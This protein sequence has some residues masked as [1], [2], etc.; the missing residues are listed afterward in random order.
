MGDV[1]RAP[2]NG[3]FVTGFDACSQ[4]L[5]GRHWL[6]PDFAWQERQD[7]TGRWDA[8]ATQEMTKT[9]SRLN[10]PAHTCQRRS[11]GNLFDR[12]TIERLA[13]QVEGH[14]ARLLDELADKLRWGEADLVSTVSEQLPISTIGS[15]LGIPPEDH[16]HI[17]EITHNQVHAQEL[18]PT[19]SQLAVSAEATVQLRAYF[20]DLVARRR[21]APGEDVLTGWIHTWDGLEPDRETADEILY[22]LTMFVTIASLE[23]T[24]TLLSSMVA[25]LLEEPG[26]WAWLREHP[27]HIDAAIDEVLRYDPPIHINSRIAAEDTVLAGVPIAKDSMVHVLYGAANHDPRRNEDPD[28]FDI[29][30]GGGHLTFGG[31]V[32]YCLGAALA[33]LEART[34]LTALLDRFPAL[35]AAAPPDYA[36]RMVFRRVTSM[37]VTA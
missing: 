3:Y 8:I 35:R 29:L 23:T 28:T 12:S 16:P 14:V 15:W 2:W 24:A 13:P 26:R 37:S 30:R 21:A 32:H 19:R 17:L 11:L 4:V 31:G 7:D 5:R 20:T 22:R 27:E 1:V 25:L 6:A 34:L 36:S 10:A 9:L 18:L 33:R